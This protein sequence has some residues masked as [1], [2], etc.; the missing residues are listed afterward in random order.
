MANAPLAVLLGN[1]KSG[2]SEG[3]AIAQNDAIFAM[4]IYGQRSEIVVPPRFSTG[5]ETAVAGA[6]SYYV[7]VDYMPDDTSATTFFS[8]LWDALD[9]ATNPTGELYFEGTLH[10]SGAVSADNP[11]W[12]GTLLVTDAGIGGASN[13][14]SRR[15]GRFRL[16]GR[17][18]KE[19][20]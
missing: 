6:A 1:F 2:A 18:V 12:S 4:T 16:T 11:K 7:E 14:L 13:S 8:Q 3:T 10:D 5:T 20:S 9:P 15:T 19:T 17:P